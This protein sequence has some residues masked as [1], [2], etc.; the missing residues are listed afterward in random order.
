VDKRGRGVGVKIGEPNEK[1]VDYETKNNTKY[2]TLGGGQKRT[3]A[4]K[5]KD[6]K[7]SKGQNINGVDQKWEHLKI[8]NKDRMYLGEEG[9]GNTR[10][11]RGKITRDEKEN[12]GELLYGKE[13]CEEMS[14]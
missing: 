4:T 14:A 3:P 11:K 1:K 8:P 7:K 2:G 5:W 6:V 12:R 10:K 13:K 9:T